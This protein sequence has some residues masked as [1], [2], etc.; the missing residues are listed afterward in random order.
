MRVLVGVLIFAVVAIGLTQLNACSPQPGAT[1]AQG[2]PGLFGMVK[3]QLDAAGTRQAAENAAYQAGQSESAF[4]A[5]QTA[6][7]EDIARAEAQR[8]ATEQSISAQATGTAVAAAQATAEAVGAT[9]TAQSWVIV[10]W[11]ATAGSARAT[12]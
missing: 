9:A 3:G 12:S 8:Q 2:D 1:P 6:R 4:I 11:T 10:G 5:A 7:A